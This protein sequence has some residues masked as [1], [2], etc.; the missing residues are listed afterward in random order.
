MDA[1]EKEVRN[2]P[3]LKGEWVKVEASR[4]H[5]FT[6]VVLKECGSWSTGLALKYGIV[7]PLRMAR[8]E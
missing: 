8:N 1:L 5:P 4:D 7:L 6:R 2:V 3:T